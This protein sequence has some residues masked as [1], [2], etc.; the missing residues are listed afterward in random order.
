MSK[1]DFSKKVMAFAFAVAGLTLIGSDVQ[2]Q[3]FE[4]PEISNDSNNSIINNGN[5]KQ[6]K[7]LSNVKIMPAARNDK[8]SHSEALAEESQGITSLTRKLTGT[9]TGAAA[10]IAPTL[11]SLQSKANTEV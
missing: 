7:L 4:L 1:K 10:E 9:I 3:G 5:K 6:H 2:A 11:N 8:L